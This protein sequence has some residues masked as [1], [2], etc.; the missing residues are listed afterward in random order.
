MLAFRIMQ[1]DGF[2]RERKYRS[3]SSYIYLSDNLGG[4]VLKEEHAEASG[5]SAAVGK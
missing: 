5:G 3:M 2:G 4:L 1:Q